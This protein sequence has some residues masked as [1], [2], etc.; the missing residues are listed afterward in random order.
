MKTYQIV[1]DNNGK[2]QVTQDGMDKDIAVQT[3]TEWW[4]QLDHNGTFE[5]YA[6]EW[7]K[8]GKRYGYT[9]DTQVVYAELEN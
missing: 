7:S 6:P 5:E 4:A 2:V 3:I 1:V 9:R 8:D